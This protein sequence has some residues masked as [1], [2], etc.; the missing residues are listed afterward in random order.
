VRTGNH[1]NEFSLTYLP[2]HYSF[3]YQPSVLDDTQMKR[4]RPQSAVLGTAA[5]FEPVPVDDVNTTTHGYPSASGR[6]L[7]AAQRKKRRFNQE[8]LEA[9]QER[10]NALR[11]IPEYVF[12]LK[13][14]GTTSPFLTQKHLNANFIDSR[15]Y[16]EMALERK[17]RS[18]DRLTEQK[19]KLITHVVSDI[20]NQQNLRFV[21]D[22]TTVKVATADPGV[23][24]TTNGIDAQLQQL[25]HGQNE[26]IPLDDLVRNLNGAIDLA[27]T[28]TVEAECDLDDD[29]MEW[30]LRPEHSG[31]INYTPIYQQALSL[32]CAKLERLVGL[33]L[34]T[35]ELVLYGQKGGLIPEDENINTLL[36]SFVGH[37][38]KDNATMV[39][40]R[41]PTKAQLQKLAHER[42][43]LVNELQVRLGSGVSAW[44]TSTRRWGNPWSRNLVRLA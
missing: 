24:Q 19:S 23:A 44:S 7:T 22:G 13:V 16:I 38:M 34:T 12:M 35:E 17:A 18:A 14:E 33:K 39:I 28:T 1:V 27:S 40:T 11:K 2:Q 3:I 21:S 31:V 5:P 41:H 36:A 20:A 42:A 4:G 29:D 37:E 32:V 30:A 9:E 26:P 15:K 43:D 8:W 25:R 10:E 6:V